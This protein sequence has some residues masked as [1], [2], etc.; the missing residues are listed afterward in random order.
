MALRPYQTAALVDDAACR[1]MG[2][3]VVC[4]VGPTG[5]GKTMTAREWSRLPERGYAGA[6]IAHRTELL[7]QAFE[8]G[9]RGCRYAMVQSARETIDA[10]ARADFVILDECHHLYGTPRWSEAIA[11]CR[12]KPTLAL[13]ATPERG[14]G[15][16]L[17]NLAD[18]IVV[19]AQP[20]QLIADGFLVPCDVIAPAAP[21]RA[22]S[23]D[24]VKAW[25]KHAP[26]QK[27]IVF[28]RD[29]KH[30][31][32]VADDF[33]NAG[34]PAGCV[35]GKMPEELRAARLA[36]HRSGELL[37]VTNVHILT[38]GYDDPSVSCEIL[39]SGCSTAGAWLQRVGR[40]VRPYPGKLRAT[41]IDLRGSVYLWG[42]P[43]Q[44]RVYSL[45]G[46]A[47]ATVGD[48]SEAI[49]QC[50]V[51]QRVF[52]A[53]EYKDATCP[54]CGARTKGKPDPRVRR[55]AMARVLATHS[56]EDKRRK[57]GELIATAKARGYSIKWA[58]VQY[59]L[60]YGH[61]PGKEAR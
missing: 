46:K 51:C 15:A 60:R 28:C 58:T 55:E 7:K 41:V 26:G 47:I 44:D 17:G 61:W 59:K 54:A 25:Q 18:A 27:A 3:N 34:V 9:V 6:F 52:L 35:D 21:T 57:F 42:L 53:S 13:T 23:E 11:G 12:G 50:Q 20:R 32:Q 4:L 31:Q 14:D 39:C 10:I 16:P 2:A 38:E 5:S 29:V 48:E 36:A 49:R 37:V 56:P 1:V 43:D 24:P 19:A 8:S 45:Q 33:R 40:I 30:A 22:M